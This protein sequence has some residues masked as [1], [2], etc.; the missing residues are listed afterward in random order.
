M[1]TEI[2]FTHQSG[3]TVHTVPEAFQQTVTLRPDQVALRTV[4]GTQQITWRDYDRRVRAIAAGL[5]KLGVHHGDTVALMLTNR[6]EF[7]LVDTAALHLGAT[8]FSVYN[9]SSAEQIKHLFTNAENRIAV[10]E[11]AFL[12][13]VRGAGVDL[14]HLI[15]VDGPAADTLSLADVEADPAPD[16]DFDAAW[17]AV[18]PDD[19]VTLIYTSGT[20]GPSKGVEITHS[21]VVAQIAG[22][23]RG[24]LIVGLDDRGVSYL[25][26]AHVADRISGHCANL[27]TG[28]ALTC[29]PDPREIAAALPDARPTAFFG[30]PR[31][32][33]KLKA[34]IDARLATEPSPVKKALAHWALGVGVAAARARLTGGPTRP[35][36]AAQHTL[37]D[38]LVL[39]KLRA[40]LGMDEL[41]VASSGAAAIP[42][43]TLEFLLGLGFTVTE[44][45][46]M[47]E[48]SGVGTFTELDKPRPGSVGRALDGVEL[49][50]DTDGELL[51][52]G[53]IVTPGY[54]KM[55]DK[56][57]E[58]I[59]ADGWLHTGDVATIDADGYVT[60]VD[61]KK[62][63]II[64]EAGKNI[65]PTNI[66]NAVKAAS[67][68]VGQVVAVGDARPYITAL[69]VLDPDTAAVRA[70]ALGIPDAP[71]AT[72]ATRPELVEEITAAVRSGNTKISRVE[73]I[74]RFR[75]LPTA[76]EPGGEEI[77]P[78][79]KLKRRPISTKYAAEIAELYGDAASDGVIDV[80]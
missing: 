67:S 46:G 1:T 10:T 19:L 33:Q 79:L 17:Q 23:M 8:P 76:W 39:S 78:T 70:K 36:L 65:S 41:R 22:L 25:P 4:G 66:E 53:A 14:E 63:L 16:F 18:R 21:N 5:A 74:K 64:T 59:D 27:F 20:T 28:I 37:A 73:Q 30:V 35:L 13:A 7:N 58:A 69:I 57:A 15:V 2:G 31:V 45:W 61:R 29:V 72:L 55:P 12:D 49:R 48:T 44:V 34:G 77:T 68:L 75:I 54:R 56:T 50:L 24:P 38:A 26:A 60:I 71:L 32:W 3:V 42:P 43:E 52:R 6:P 40:A 47:S 9:T 62:E 80:K 11:R 51:V